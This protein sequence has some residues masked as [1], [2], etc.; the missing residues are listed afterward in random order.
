MGLEIFETNAITL[1]V[2]NCLRHYLVGITDSDLVEIKLPNDILVKDKKLAGVLTEISYPY[3]VIGIGINL[4]NSPIER[5]TNLQ[6][7]F[8]LLVKPNDLVENLFEVLIKGLQ[9]CCSH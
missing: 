3:A 4:I 7:E 1:I 6:S 9:G 8:N 2:M 5:A